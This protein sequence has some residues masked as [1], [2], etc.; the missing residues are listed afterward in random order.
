[1]GAEPGKPTVTVM[2]LG[3]VL[4]GDDALGPFVIRRLLAA[5]EFNSDVALLDLGTPGIELSP[6]IAGQKA[7][8]VVETVLADGVPGTLKLYRRD[9][10]LQHSPTERLSPHDAGLKETLLALELHDQPPPEVLVVG[11][12]PDQAEVGI[13]LSD[14]VRDAVP[15]VMAAVLIELDR[16]GRPARPAKDPAEPD[17]W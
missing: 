10:L 13:G 11:V 15:R 8:V 5:Y 3:S 17:I 9:A 12:I 16:L 4:M 6:Y 2:G 7:L 14:A 1:M